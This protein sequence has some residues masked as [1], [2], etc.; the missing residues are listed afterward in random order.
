MKNIHV[1][2]STF[3]VLRS[4]C[5]VLRSTPTF[6]AAMRFG[7]RAGPQVQEEPGVDHPCAYGEC[8]HT[9]GVGRREVLS[10]LAVYQTVLSF[11]KFSI[12]DF[13]APRKF[14]RPSARTLRR[15]SS[16][17]KPPRPESDLGTRSLCRRGRILSARTPRASLRSQVARLPGLEIAALSFHFQVHT[18]FHNGP[19]RKC[20]QNRTNVERRTTN[21]E[22]RTQNV[23]RLHHAWRAVYAP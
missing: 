11:R 21:G 14:L 16:A 17:P 2:R 8:D 12:G 9:I 18:A 20:E 19:P 3:S 7:F 6:W 10:V 1:L 4:S 23:E 5:C 15:C 13:A 22:R